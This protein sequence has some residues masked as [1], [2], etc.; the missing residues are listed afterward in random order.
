MN[1][2]IWT[3]EEDKLLIK[4]F[5]TTTITEMIN[6]LNKT[7]SK[8]RTRISKVVTI[9][10]RKGYPWSQIE[11]EILFKHYG[12]MPLEKLSKLVVRTPRAI[13]DRVKRLEG[14]ID[15]STVTGNY[16]SVDLVQY[17]GVDASTIGNW[18]RRG[19][20]PMVRVNKDYFIEQDV[21]WK[22][23]KNNTELI[24]TNKVNDSDIIGTPKWYQDFIASG[25]R[26]DKRLH[27]PFTP[28]EDALIWRL[29]TNGVKIEEITS[30]TKRT[31][32]SVSHRLR[33][34]RSQKWN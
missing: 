28:T 10:S 27:V 6:Q 30:N 4:L 25:K 2:D 16:K 23:L 21:F 34:L 19:K 20:L 12:N 8:V 32:H 13:K 3:E 5:N 24:R 11:D 15:I 26:K 7:E 17:T 29:Y 18:V 31:Y 33:K 22:W 9:E 1:K 14:V